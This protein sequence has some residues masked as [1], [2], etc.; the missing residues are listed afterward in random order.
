[1]ASTDERERA[2]LELDVRDKEYR[3]KRS[4]NA[5]N[6]SRLERAKRRLRE[7]AMLDLRMR[8]RQWERDRQRKERNAEIRVSSQMN[9]AS[10]AVSK[11]FKGIDGGLDTPAFQ[12]AR[13]Y[14]IG[15][16]PCQ[17]PPPPLQRQSPGKPKIKGEI[18][19]IYIV[20]IP[21]PEP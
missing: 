2:F 1:M 17:C 6:R 11:G 14:A 18:V 16:N 10:A 9:V 12:Q 3:L 21:D 19:F 15:R 4:P 8:T 13:P 20:D 5:T 7:R